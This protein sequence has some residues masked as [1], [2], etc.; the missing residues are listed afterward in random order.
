MKDQRIPFLFLFLILAFSVKAQ[1]RQAS[2]MIEKGVPEALAIYRQKVMSKVRYALHLDIPSDRNANIAGRETVSFELKKDG[3]PVLL[4]F[5]EERDHLKTIHVNGKSISIDFRNE[6]IIIPARYLISGL[7]T[8]KI[9]F[10]AGELSLNRNREFLYTLLV[11][12]RS[13][14]LY[15]VFD[16]PG[17][18]AR[19]QLSLTLPND[20][21]AL[22]N[23]PLKDSVVKGNNKTYH[24]EES[25]VFSTYLFSFTAGKFDK[26]S[27][28]VNGRPMHFFY[29]ETDS[30]KLR[31]S[32][33]TVFGL[34][35]ASLKYLEDYTAIKYPFKKFDFVAIPDF[36]YGGMEHV[37][38]IDYKASTLFLD[39][40]AT[41][42]QENARSGLI[43]HETAHMWFG[44]LV[45]MQW[46]NDVWMKEVFANFMADKITQGQQEKSNY[47]LKFLLTH[48]P[49]AYSIDRTEGALPIRQPLSN[50]QEAGTLYG[51]IIYNKAPVM[52]RQLERLMGEKAFRDGLRTYLSRY[53]YGNATWPDLIKI[54]DRL[55]PADLEAW[56]KVWVN[57][58]GRP[59]IEYSIEQ[60]KGLITKF[61]ITQ[62]GERSSNYVLP[63][64]FEISLV[65]A[66]HVKELTVNMNRS[67]VE[68]K[69]LKNRPMPLY[70]V[71]NSSGQGYGM[72]PVDSKMFSQ[73]GKLK[74]PVERA[75]VYINLYENML[76]GNA[77]RPVEL[78]NLYLENVT[79]ESEELNL[80]MMTGYITDIYWRLLLPADRTAMAPK[81]E[82]I[83]WNAMKNETLPNKKK[84]LFRTFQ[85]LALSKNSLDMVY[86]IWKDQQPPMGVRLSEDD[87]TTISLNLAVKD[88][89]ARQILDEQIVRVS[90]PDR[91][92]RLQFLLPALS[93][94]EK[95]RETFFTSL[96]DQKIR[97]K[98]AWVADALSYLH[99]PLRSF[100]SKKYLKAS[101][102]ML[103]DIQLTGDIFFLSAWLN[104]SFGSY[105]T[106]EA[107]NV[108]RSFLEL[109]PGYNPKLLAKILQAADGLFRAEKLLN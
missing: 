78:L 92:L 83:L 14:T 40:G 31:L 59:N 66:D 84:I 74:S 1:T 107:A 81:V 96:R 19:Y 109:N 43:A 102:E 103:Q 101:L 85:H 16:Q 106:S 90:D 11:P 56:N 70:V 32:M 24:Y 4:D 60:E 20:W 35:A 5:K 36:Q 98:E 89:P 58:A 26:R 57:T 25:D 64:F 13:R 9:N 27:K 86:R 17:L 38:A 93:S 12:D 104:A 22:T 65:Y 29:R 51:P 63:Q 80:G 95:T 49:R 18:K 55:T 61:S 39:S 50:L 15:P 94:D 7:N 10:I 97:K 3:N 21:Q 77:M 99:H 42:D 73:I 69:E 41:K 47:A 8:V 71:F 72:F 100:S 30:N 88:Y 68:L 28:V 2:D 91:K 45:T 75:S 54:L 52:M 44:D 79:K 67:E 105:Q 76:S 82:N 33:D 23:A 53:S 46:F 87:Y 6:H 34:H 108:V 48:F 37:G 62:K